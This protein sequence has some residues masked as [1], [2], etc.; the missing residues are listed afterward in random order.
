MV[1]FNTKKHRKSYKWNGFSYINS[2]IC[3]IFSTF[4][5]ELRVYD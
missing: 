2:V 4:V 3:I 1:S 5:A